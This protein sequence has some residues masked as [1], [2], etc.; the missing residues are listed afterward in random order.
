MYISVANVLLLDHDL[1]NMASQ[2]PLNVYKGSHSI[3]DY[4]DP[5]KAPFLPLVELPPHVNPYYLQGV[6]IYAKMMNAL[7]GHNVKALP[8]QCNLLTLPSLVLSSHSIVVSSF[9]PPATAQKTRNGNRRGIQLRLDG[10]LVG[11]L[12]TSAVRSDR[13]MG[14]RKQ[15]DSFNK[16]T[17]T[18]VLWVKDVSVP[19]PAGLSFGCELSSFRRKLFG[20]PST[21]DPDDVRGGIYAAEQAQ[22]ENDKVLNP[23]QYVKDAVSVQSCNVCVSKWLKNSHRTG[24]HILCGPDHR[25]SNSFQR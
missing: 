6:R 16:D 8:G 10:R 12:V 24:R 7:P 17:V 4:H 25:F 19:I 18:P 9:E 2:N 22:S 5:E 3:R 15:Q 21:P 1:S 14:I 11:H 20:G 13:Y 23:N